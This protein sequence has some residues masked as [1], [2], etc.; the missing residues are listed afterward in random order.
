MLGIA[1]PPVLSF[2]L[3]L[4]SA[5]PFSHGCS[6]SSSGSA[7]LNGARSHMHLVAFAFSQA[8]AAPPRP[9]GCLCS[10]RCCQHPQRHSS[11]TQHGFLTWGSSPTA[12]GSGSCP[13]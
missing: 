6:F 2:S 7:G 9:R 11:P 12:R 5:L 1:L 8:V 4:E 10:R 13:A 3:C